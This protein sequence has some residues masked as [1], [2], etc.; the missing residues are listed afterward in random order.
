M[1]TETISQLPIALSTNATADYL[2]ISQY[3]TAPGTTYIS[4]RITPANLYSTV[5]LRAIPVPSAS[6]PA[7]PPTGQIAATSQ[8]SSPVIGNA[9]VT[10]GSAYALLTW[11]GT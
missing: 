5:S 10:G 6:L 4:K 2:E 7:S 9:L 3:S 11:N 1:A 8:A